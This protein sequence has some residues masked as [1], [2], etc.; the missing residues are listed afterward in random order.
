MQGLGPGG[1]GQNCRYAE[2]IIAIQRAFNAMVAAV[3]AEGEHIIEDLGT[4]IR[5]WTDQHLEM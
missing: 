2:G 5:A 3:M 4:E 1:G